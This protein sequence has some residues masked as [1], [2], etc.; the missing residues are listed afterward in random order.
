MSNPCP[1]TTHRP[2]DKPSNQ[3]TTKLTVYLLRFVHTANPQ[4][5]SFN[6]TLSECYCCLVKQ[7]RRRA[8]NASCSP[9]DSLLR[10]L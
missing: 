8:E 5:T 10:V 2:S 4:N 9:I 3:L 6:A 1:E 7:R